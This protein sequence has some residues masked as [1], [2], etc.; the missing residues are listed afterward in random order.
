MYVVQQGGPLSQHDV[1]VGH[2]DSCNITFL[3]H[4]S[5]VRHEEE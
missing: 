3:Y 1:V 4:R 2:T 5:G